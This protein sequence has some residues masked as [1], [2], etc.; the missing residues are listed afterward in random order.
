MAGA[1]DELVRKV[2]APDVH[3]RFLEEIDLL[4]GAGAGFYLEALRAG[5]Q[6][7]VFFCS[8]M[9]NFG[10]R[11]LLDRFLEFAPPPSGRVA[12]GG[13]VA[14]SAPPFSGFVFKVQANM[15]PRHR[16][17]VAFVRIVSGGF[18]RAM[19]AHNPRTGRD[20]R[21]SNAQR[22]FARER[23]TVDDAWPGDVVGLVGNYDIQIGDT[24]SE[25]AT[26]VFHEIP[27]FPPECFA[28]VHCSTSAMQ[29]RF[30]AGL[31]QLLKE[32]VAQRFHPEGAVTAAPLLGAVGPLQFD[33]LRH[34]L[35]SEYGAE[36]RLE[37]A[38]WNLVRWLPAMT[39]LENSLLMLP[40]GVVRASDEDNRTV[41]L[42][43]SAWALRYFTEKHAHITLAETAPQGPGG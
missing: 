5:R 27:R 36:C 35:L 2:L 10:V 30:R 37:T 25:D 4:D 17:R 29:K 9:N 20:L 23:E 31:D 24:L 42:F 41:L 3:A 38:S 22:L 11:L 15:N 12:A 34:R 39:A 13:P 6:T 7:A 8:A 43:D 32:G 26:V 1:D 14:P 28:S 33:V 16:A 19:T 18:R 21:L 40:T